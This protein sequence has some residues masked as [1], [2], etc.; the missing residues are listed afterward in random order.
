MKITRIIMSCNNHVNYINFWPLVAEI[1][2]RKDVIV[3]LF[4]IGEKSDF[5]FKQIPKTEVYF[6]PPIPKSIPSGIYARLVRL[7]AP[8]LFPKDICLITDVDI[9]PLNLKYFFD[10]SAACSEDSFVCYC[11]NFYDK[12]QPWRKPISYLCGHSNTFSEILG[13][14]LPDSNNK[15]DAYS[16]F[17]KC[18]EEWMQYGFNIQTDEYI[19]SWLLSVW[20]KKDKIVNV[21]R[22]MNY[23][24]LGKIKAVPSRLR[25]NSPLNLKK[26]RDN[27]Y[28]DFEPNRPFH[29]SYKKEAAVYKHLDFDVK[30]ITKYGR[31]IP[32]KKY[33]RNPL[34]YIVPDKM[35]E[36]IRHLKQNHAKIVR[37]EPIVKYK[38]N[39]GSTFEHIFKA[40][41][42]NSVYYKKHVDRATLFHKRKILTLAEKKMYIKACKQKLK[43]R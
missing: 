10:K 37:K 12:L 41:K 9:V 25:K 22:Y 43:L 3:T 24:P 4:F 36:S 39:T 20:E 26:L 15:Q 2:S 14:V 31:K 35:L 29:E 34:Y 38:G 5:K 21:K 19:F 17:E 18:I 33:P 7:F 13:I 8:L 40:L 32:E 30:S 27:F 16:I 23:T 1:W 42:I 6:V 28:I 11:S